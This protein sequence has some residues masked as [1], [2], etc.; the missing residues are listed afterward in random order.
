M[1]R[2][3]KSTQPKR[4]ILLQKTKIPAAQRFA[5]LKN[6]DNL[7]LALKASA[8][9]AAA[10]ALYFQDL[11]IIFTDAVNNESTSYILA[12]PL[13]FAYLLYRKRRMLRA[14]IPSEASN[15][16]KD[17]RYLATLTGIL[18]CTTAIVL[19]WYGSYTFTPLEYHVLTLP[20]FTSGLI[21]LLFGTQTMRQLAIPVVFLFFLTPPPSEILYNLGS[22][23]SVISSE[24]SN[25]IVSALGIPSTLVSEN[26]T[27]TITITRPDSST[28][29]FAVDIAC[30]GIY[31]LL[32]FLVFAAFIAY[33]VRDKTWKKIS[34]FAI[35][36]PLIYALNIA[37]ITTIVLIGYQFGEQLALDL[38]HLLGGWILIFI[39]TL[40]L[41]L[42]SEKAFRTRIFINPREKCSKCNPRPEPDQ[43]FCQACGRLLKPGNI[44]LHKI[45]VVKILAI[46]LSV[47]L[48]TSIQA[49]A[50]A[51]TKAGPM[52]IISTP[53]GEQVST[54]ILPQIQ[55]YNLSFI[56]RD[57][58]FEARAKQ[59]MSLIYIYAP[60]NR[61]MYPVWV[62][63]EIAST[64][65]SL[66]S[67]EV[68]L[69]T[70]P[71]T[72]GQQLTVSQID[73][74]DIQLTQNPPIISRYFVFQYKKNN[75]TEA[76]LYWRETS[77]FTVNSTSQTK[78]VKISLI[79][80]P[81]N[82]DDL[83][84]IENQLVTLA[85][86]ITAYW[87]PIKTW[88]QITMLIS[89]NGPN[90]ATATGT[91][92]IATT[93]LYYFQTKRRKKANTTA[94]E[95]LSKPNQEIVDTIHKTEKRTQPTLNNIKTTYE[96]TTKQPIDPEQLQQKLLEL[97]KTSIIESSIANKQDEPIQTWK[98]Q[99]NLK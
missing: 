64:Q 30:S 6:M 52:T 67:W 36:F 93:I 78:H 74:K 83:P 81:E 92:V 38:F 85:T 66:H 37:R 17:T 73:L 34:T 82:L 69:I 3:N 87:Q 77:T 58:A 41:L 16:P 29:N 60:N 8:I 25:A 80:Y 84:G 45:D 35:G 31:S 53:S 43:S 1:T 5:A 33:A 15:Q 59:D 63:I 91:M 56:Y 95:K 21:L 48:M 24:A 7:A 19:Y 98:T 40:I 12:I 26:G 13:L 62:A 4:I 79:T 97:E 42:A 46:A 2:N 65:A 50:F 89:Q 9:I 49:P 22:S 54:E 94:Y 20:I 55:D 88:S 90:L 86:A 75:I 99:A 61:S 44:A 11:S 28:M 10:V 18:L 68:C 57:T 71:T 39:G 14:V 70:W 96:E 23:L 51:L 76:V 32:G 72:Q 27:P 47:G